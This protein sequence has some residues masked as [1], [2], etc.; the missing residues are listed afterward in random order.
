MILN[1]GCIMLFK[2]NNVQR[3]N[4][5]DIWSLQLRAFVTNQN[6][7]EGMARMKILWLA[8]IFIE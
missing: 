6:T 1:K 5:I 2:H 8:S 7:G 4:R 3:I